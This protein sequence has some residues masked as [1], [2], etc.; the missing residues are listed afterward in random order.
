MNFM[1]ESES[2]NISKA[3]KFTKAESFRRFF[4]YQ[5]RLSNIIF[6]KILFVEVFFPFS[7]FSISLVTLPQNCLP[8]NLC[9]ASELQLKPRDFDVFILNECKAIVNFS[10]TQT[11]FFQQQIVPASTQ[12][13]FRSF[14]YL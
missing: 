10:S 11:S 14:Q 2:I 3:S 7:N 6:I 4:V 9:K 8:L 1:H 13:T 5:I 12:R